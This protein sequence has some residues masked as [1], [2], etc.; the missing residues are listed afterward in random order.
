MN[1]AACWVA[2]V[3]AVVLGSAGLGRAGDAPEAIK[4]ADLTQ[5]LA[6]D[7]KATKAKYDGKALV[8]EGKVVAVQA[9]ADSAV[10]ITLE[11]HN[12]KDKDPIR[13]VCAF[14]DAQ[15]D[16]V[17]KVEKGATVKIKGEFSKSGSSL[18]QAKVQLVT[19]DLVK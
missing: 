14:A 9:K 4:A 10:S 15:L 16:A 5:E 8:V 18:F 17:K 12:E 1:R 6:K 13:V 11:G 3:S 2:I 19:C 7:E